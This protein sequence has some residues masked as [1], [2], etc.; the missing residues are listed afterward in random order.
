MPE[1]L[2]RNVL[3]WCNSNSTYTS[4]L[5]ID[6]VSDP[7]I[8]EHYVQLVG[9]LQEGVIVPFPLVFRNIHELRTE[10]E[11]LPDERAAILRP[12][13]EIAR[14]EMT[15][16]YANYGKSSDLLRYLILYLEGGVYLDSDIVPNEG[17]FSQFLRPQP[18]PHLLWVDPNSQ[19]TNLVGNDAFATTAQHYFF[20]TVLQWAWLNY[21]TPFDITLREI[22]QTHFLRQILMPQ[23]I[24]FLEDPD[25]RKFSTIAQTG[26][27]LIQDVLR[28]Y[29]VLDGNQ[30]VPTEGFETFPGPFKAR[31]EN[32]QTWLNPPP[33]QKK[34]YELCLTNAVQTIQCEVNTLRWLRIVDHVEYIKAHTL[35]GELRTDEVIVHD[36]I[37]RLKGMGLHY[38]AV[39]EVQVSY[40]T[41]LLTEFYAQQVPDQYRQAKQ[42]FF[43]G[44]DYDLSPLRFLKRNGYFIDK[45]MSPCDAPVYIQL[46]QDY[47][48][49]YQHLLAEALSTEAIAE[50]RQFSTDVVT[51]RPSGVWDPDMH[52][53]VHVLQDQIQELDIAASQL[54]SQPV[55][56]AL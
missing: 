7:G 14:Y 25:Y 44:V 41:M 12:L 29:Q 43:P 27:T 15:K 21:T 45:Y 53:A 31:G 18:I 22:G 48:V 42:R 35:E 30:W 11:Q 20:L 1:L 5:W 9:I 40:L 28:Y 54:E 13:F 6:P 34:A 56:V 16:P 39:R 23:P 3:H 47:V 26:P 19:E 8:E 38:L 17:D 51:L 2:M 49:H 24:Y 4:Y 37:E 10:I 50:L 36:V 33:P 32:A 46:L 52:H 55:V